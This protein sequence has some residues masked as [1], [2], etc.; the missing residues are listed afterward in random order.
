MR[1]SWLCV[2]VPQKLSL[3][4]YHGIDQPKSSQGDVR[5]L[6]WSPGRIIGPAIVIFALGL[7][8]LATHSADHARQKPSMFLVSCGRLAVFPSSLDLRALP[9]S[10]HETCS[11]EV[12]E[13]EYGAASQSSASSTRIRGRVRQE[14]SRKLF[15]LRRM[16]WHD[17]NGPA[18]YG[19]DAILRRGYV[20]K[21]SSLF[22]PRS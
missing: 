15:H 19:C 16:E 3:L 18:V 21:T 1:W 12:A 9:R 6:C 11:D 8:H 14:V 7:V 10:H 4:R 5:Y 17:D 20:S 13:V 2:R 22:C